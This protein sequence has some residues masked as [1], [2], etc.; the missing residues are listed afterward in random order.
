[1]AGLIVIATVAVVGAVG[2]KVRGPLEY[3]Q[4]G[5][6]RLW[7]RRAVRW[8]RKGAMRLP[9]ELIE[10]MLWSLGSQESGDGNRRAPRVGMRC[11]AMLT[12]VEGG[13]A[14]D[15]EAREVL[16]R[17]ISADGA[18][19]LLASPLRVPRFVLE[20]PNTRTGPVSILCATRHC[21]RSPEGGYVV[22]AQFRRFLPRPAGQTG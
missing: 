11:I 16:V 1:M 6:V 9:D 3:G 13:C 8:G 12:P 14:R 10:S 4:R 21:D 2:T 22:G 18:S 19:L 17:D 7:P 5:P 20:I 15:G